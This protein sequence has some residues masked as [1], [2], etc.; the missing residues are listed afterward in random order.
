VL[1]GERR[2][3]P[4]HL[5]LDP[6]R[7]GLVVLDLAAPLAGEGLPSFYAGSESIQVERAAESE[8][9]SEAERAAVEYAEAMTVT[10][11]K[12]TEELFERLRAQ[13]AEAAIVEL[14]AAVALLFLAS[15]TATS[16]YILA[17]QLG[18]DAKLMAGI[19]TA[20]TGAAMV[21]LPVVLTLA[22]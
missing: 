18:G 6:P 4:R 7:L 10:G 11:R 19:L 9:F 12:V 16:S 1:L 2:D 21:T 22:G 15:P 5:L 17:R 14:T 20:Q 13:F 3:L 8:L